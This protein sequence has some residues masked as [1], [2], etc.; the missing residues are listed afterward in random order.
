[1]GFYLLKKSHEPVEGHLVMRMSAVRHTHYALLI[2][3]LV[4]MHLVVVW[5][6]SD[7]NRLVRQVLLDGSVFKGLR[8]VHCKQVDSMNFNRYEGDTST[9]VKIPTD[10]VA[11]VSERILSAPSSERHGDVTNPGQLPWAI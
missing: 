5:K 10:P 1:M 3:Q 8:C 4:Q 2:A 11:T 9:S 6:T 7:G